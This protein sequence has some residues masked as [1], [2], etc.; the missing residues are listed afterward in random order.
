M[1]KSPLSSERLSKSDLCRHSPLCSG[2][3]LC[4]FGSIAEKALRN[5][6]SGSAW[7]GVGAGEERGEY[8]FR[9]DYLFS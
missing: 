7:L 9:S 2:G 3:D 8:L 1:E 5:L 6:S 4:G